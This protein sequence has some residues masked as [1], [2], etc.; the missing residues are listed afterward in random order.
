MKGYIRKRGK[1]YSYT[2]DIGKDPITGK[3]KQKT[4]SGF[5]TKK[6]AQAALNEVVYEVNKGIYILDNNCTFKELA[7]EWLEHNKHKWA[8]T[9]FEVTYRMVMN[10]IVT[11]FPAIKVQDITP[12]H[13]KKLLADLSESLAPSTVNRIMSLTSQILNYAVDTELINKNPFK[14]IPHI[15]ER[16]SDKKTW[17][18]EEINQFLKTAVLDNPFYYRIV[19]VTVFTGMRK[20]E[21]FGLRKTDIDFKNNIININQSLHETNEHGLILGGPKT[22]TSKRAIAVNEDVIKIL[23]EQIR[24]NNECKLALG[25][26][27]EDNGLVFCREDGIPYRP[28]SLN[29]PFNRLTKKAGVPQIRFHD[30]RHTH[31]TLL[32][33][34]GANPKVIADRLGHADIK[35]TLNTYSHVTANMQDKAMNDFVNA[36]KMSK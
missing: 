18:F 16:E 13:G 30:L 14:S 10:Q 11:K 6:E 22:K 1:G 29:R 7:E 31:A 33:E 24:R 19:F 4:K 15:R 3:R 8:Q 36:Y 9:T 2:I 23:K 20:G 27:Y 12:L 17:T 21:I 25:S 5:K 35:T 34:T 32:L 26:G 28:S